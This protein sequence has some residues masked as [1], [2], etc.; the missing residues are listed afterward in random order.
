M[1][2]YAETRS[3]LIS[4]DNM[5]NKLNTGDFGYFDKFNQL[6]LVSKKLT[7]VFG[8][9]VNTD[10]IELLLMTE[11]ET[12]VLEM[13][14]KIKIFIGNLDNNIILNLLKENFNSYT[15]I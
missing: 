14:N 4:E 11:Y 12:A 7:K 8:I 10:D 9:R 1:M 5:H 6:V 2:G 13:D 15:S 3:D